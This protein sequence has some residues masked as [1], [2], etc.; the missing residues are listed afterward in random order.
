MTRSAHSRL[1]ILMNSLVIA[2]VPAALVI[3][4][5]FMLPVLP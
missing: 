4:E 3:S 2:A 1:H 5:I